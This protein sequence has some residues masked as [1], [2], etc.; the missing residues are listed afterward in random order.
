MRYYFLCLENA[1]KHDQSVFYK[2][3]ALSIYNYCTGTVLTNA[4]L[5][6]SMFGLL[7][8]SAS[9]ANG[10]SFCLQCR[11]FRPTCSIS[12]SINESI[13]CSKVVPQPSDI[14]S[15]FAR[16]FGNIVVATVRYPPRF[17]F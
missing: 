16:T 5:G 3:T 14:F 13:Q 1:L 12:Q 2:S 7:Q 11:S 9:L 15:K 17:P 10:L 8:W 6:L 4:T